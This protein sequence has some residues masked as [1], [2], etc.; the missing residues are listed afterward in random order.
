MEYNFCYASNKFHE[1]SNCIKKRHLTAAD[2]L[3]LDNSTNVLKFIKRME[4]IQQNQLGKF[5]VAIRNSELELIL[6]AF[7]EN[8]DDETRRKLLCI[9]KLRMKRRLFEINWLMLQN[10][11]QNKNLKDSMELLC[12]Y[13]KVKHKDEYAQ[14]LLGRLDRHDNDLLNQTYKTLIND[15]IILQDFLEKYNISEQ[16]CFGLNLCIMFFTE[17]NTDGFLNNSELFYRILNKFDSSRISL[18]V[19]NYLNKLDVTEFIK[20]INM[21]ILQRYNEPKLSNIMWSSV[22]HTCRMKFTQWLNIKKLEDFYGS[23]NTIYKFWLEFCKYI[24][25]IHHED[26]SIHLVIHFD[27][28]I[29]IAKA[30]YMQEA[31]LCE[32]E[33]FELKYDRYL[34]DM[35]NEVEIIEYEQIVSA[36]DAVINNINSEIYKMSFEGICKLYARDLLK[37]ELKNL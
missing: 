25:Y 11:Y 2:K 10:D 13:M 1:A 37:R 36:R 28:F 17:C 22:S 30:M 18:L 32:K 34:A 15:N 26:K 23:K 20:H 19:D 27:T 33:A 4:K 35:E 31:F 16:S 6:F 24:N 5:A 7:K 21:F 9:M 12:E 8:I 3:G 29:V 14:S